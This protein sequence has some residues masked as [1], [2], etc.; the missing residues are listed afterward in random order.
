MQDGTN[1]W[2]H[3][4]R[5]RVSRRA[6]LGGVLGAG[7]AGL[8]AAACGSGGAKS[9]STT[10]GA[11]TATAGPAAKFAASYIGPANPGGLPLWVGIDAGI[12]RQNGIDYNLQAIAGQPSIAALISGQ[13]QTASGGGSDTISAVLNGADLV[14]V[15]VLAPGVPAKLYV[16]KNIQ[17]PEDL[18]GKKVAITNPG[19]TYD[20]LA[21]EGLKKMGLDPDKDVTLIKTGSVPNVQAALMSGAVSAGPIDFGPASIKAEALGFHGIFDL[22][23]INAAGQNMAMRRDYVNANHDIVQHYV[24]AIVESIAREKKDKAFSMKSLGKWTSVDDQSQLD[25]VYTFYASDT[26]LPR[27][28]YPKPEYYPLEL[29]LIASKNPKAEG[30][31]V[32]KILDPS[33]VQ[34]AAD[35]GLDKK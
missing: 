33:F 21:R 35:R 13:T 6:V 14:I 26:V 23:T 19:S 3:V 28:P 27:L 4:L 10:A 9:S 5:E 29:Q 12:F 7:L 34:S 31:D 1:Y 15:G 22:S 25:K 11:L 17:A 16:P 30:F 8:G 20:L 32:S 18:K 2:S 24:D